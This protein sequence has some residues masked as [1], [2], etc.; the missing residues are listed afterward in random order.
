MAASDYDLLLAASGVVEKVI[1]PRSSHV[2]SYNIPQGQKMVW[3]AR[4]KKGDIGFGIKLLVESTNVMSSGTEKDIQAIE[5]YGPERQIIGELKAVN[6]DRRI[7]MIFDN[8]N[9]HINRK[10]VAYW[11]AIG[12]NVSH[13]DETVGAAR[14]L[15]V[16]IICVCVYILRVYDCI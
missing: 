11:V 5:K 12:E 2:Q 16:S 7:N 8:S 10:N 4:V 1:V 13:S 6:Y 15:E 3:K 14:T 9:G